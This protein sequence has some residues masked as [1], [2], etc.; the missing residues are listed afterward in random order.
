MR[1]AQNDGVSGFFSGVGKVTSCAERN[2]I[3]KLIALVSYRRHPGARWRRREA[4]CG[5]RR[6]LQSHCGLL[7]VDNSFVN[8]HKRRR[9][10][11]SRSNA[12]GLAQHGRRL[13]AACTRLRAS[14]VR[15]RRMVRCYCARRPFSCRQSESNVVRACI[16]ALCRW[17]TR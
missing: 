6:S 15:R 16:A 13:A 17:L 8:L 9:S 4:C 2:A 1:G 14:L 10:S 7:P 5:R 11:S 12:G 3:A